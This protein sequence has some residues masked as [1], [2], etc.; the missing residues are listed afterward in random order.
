MKVLV[1]LAHGF[2]LGYVGCYGNEWIATPALDR[3]AAEGIIFD[4]HVVDHPD[5]AQASYA[6]H[7]GCYSMPWPEWREEA[8]ESKSHPRH[9]ARLREH[10][11]PTILMRA[12][13][14]G[15]EVND[16]T[17][18]DHLHEVSSDPEEALDFTLSALDAM[19]SHEHWLA[20]VELS[21]LM[22]PWKMPD[23][24]QEAYREEEPEAEI[25]TDSL[26]DP[27]TQELLEAE[28]PTLSKLQ[29][30]FAGAVTY[31]DAVL[32]RFLSQLEDREWANDVLLVITSDFGEA[33]D[34]QR[35]GSAVQTHLHEE[36]I[37]VPLIVRFADQRAAG[38]R[39][40]ALTQPVDLLPT[41]FELF[42]LP[43][44]ADVQGR[45]LMPLLTGTSLKVRDYACAGVRVGE[46][47]EWAL[48][49][50]E[51][52]FLWPMNQPSQGTGRDPELYV[53]PDD[54]WEVNN[55]WQHHA[56]LAERLEATLQIFV[57][58][59]RQTG[60]FEPPKIPDEEKT[61]NINPPEGGI[62]G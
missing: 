50:P 55:V 21:V 52:S 11:I 3:L 14:P 53:K 59:T 62:Q 38:R 2:H 6:W 47:I 20:R 5:P 13:A 57:T 8:S 60:P 33:I 19:A 18:W 12:Q 28:R 16:R 15:D 61:Q 7:T 29:R 30:E 54:R 4:Q 17:G 1:V 39:I 58:A 40:A 10:G 45:S 35:R 36:R 42:G 23:E 32:E 22:P 25:P 44:P 37:H 43:V 51:W 56:D 49:T 26:A 34:E 24:F 27:E 48:R 9:F 31:L 46:T 41:I